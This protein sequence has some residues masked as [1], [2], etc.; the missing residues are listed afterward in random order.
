M[1]K[2]CYTSHM[3]SNEIWNH[4]AGSLRR[5]KLD[6]LVSWLLEGGAPL[7]LIGAQALYIGL[8]FVGGTQF[9]SI[10]QLLEDENE[11]QAFVQFL[12]SE[13]KER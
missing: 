1:Y 5:L 3:Q 2:I 7:H 8:P 9:E 12:R 10:A 4:W 6:G 13:V 11:L